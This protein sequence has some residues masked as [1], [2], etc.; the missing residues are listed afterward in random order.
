MPLSRRRVLALGLAAP[1][2]LPAAEPP[3]LQRLADGVYSLPGM[4]GLPAAANRGRVANCGVVI[5]PEGAIVFDTGV[6]AR[7]GRALLDA[8][9]ATTRVP[10][11]LALLSHAQQEFIFGAAA[12]RE[13]GIPTA[14]LADAATLMLARCHTCLARLTEQLGSEEM[15]GSPLRPPDRLL[16]GDTLLTETGRPL[17]LLA[18]AQAATRSDLALWDASRGTLFAGGLLDAGRIP[19][20]QDADLPGWRAAL[21]R[22][23]AL[24][25]LRQVLPGRGPAGGPAL[26]TTQLAYLDALDRA[27]RDALAAGASLAEALDWPLDPGFQAWVGHPSIHRRNLSTHYLRLEADW[28]AAPPQHR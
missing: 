10:V 22:L 6:S 11:R 3:A 14:M 25:G 24:P 4:P 28:L 27:V 8:V 1:L 12:M 19:D 9:A 17:Q 5:G 15:A 20:L 23:A 18:F 13:R 16:T 26:I 7:H 21:E 2:A